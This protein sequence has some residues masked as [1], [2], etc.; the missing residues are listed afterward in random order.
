M[1]GL[2]L[3]KI[4]S[5]RRYQRKPQFLRFIDPTPISY[6]E[7]TE[8]NSDSNS[9]SYRLR[10]ANFVIFTLPLS[11]RENRPHFLGLLPPVVNPL[12]YT[13]LGCSIIAT[14]YPANRRGQELLLRA[15]AVARPRLH[16]ALKAFYAFPT[17]AH[18]HSS[19]SII[20][21][22]EHRDDWCLF[23]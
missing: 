23:W 15:A 10:T 3:S 16:C 14:M 5:R 2:T 13:Q 22:D 9:M 1:S 21:I 7:Q 8:L 12:G 4:S 20:L 19:R 6:L 11:G 18:P 17:P